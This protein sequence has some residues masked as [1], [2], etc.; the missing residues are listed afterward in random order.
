MS[1]PLKAT[2]ISALVF[3]G[4][5]HFYIKRYFTGALLAGISLVCLLLLLSIAMEAAQVISQKILNGEIP[6]D[7]LRIRAEIY[8]QS[9]AIGSTRGEI[10]TWI[11]I[12]CWLASIADSYRLSRKQH[13]AEEKSDQSHTG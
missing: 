6:L 12:V 2:L 13:Q 4:G 11:L 7:V 9:S 3:P 5:G 8:A 1:P 10:A